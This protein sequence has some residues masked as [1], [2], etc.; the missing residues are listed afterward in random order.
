MNR[1]GSLTLIIG[2]AVLIVVGLACGAEKKQ[3]PANAGPASDAQQ[4]QGHPG[5]SGSPA[6]NT[7]TLVPAGAPLVSLTYEG[8]VYYQDPLSTDAAANL[9][10]DDLELVG[11]TTESNLLAPGGGE[12]L[13]IYRLKNDENGYVYT[14]EPEHEQ[15][16]QDEGED[17]HTITITTTTIEA[18]WVRWTVADSNQTAP[19]SSENDGTPSNHR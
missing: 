7:S 3:D 18:E 13:D 4:A 9:K 11:V 12:S 1:I 10:E 17:G 8:T 5:P 14:L 15:S 19:V 6:E 2:L 16:V